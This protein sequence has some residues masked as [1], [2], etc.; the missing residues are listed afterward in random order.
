MAPPG[1]TYGIHGFEGWSFTDRKEHWIPEASSG[2]I[3][4]SSRTERIQAL[5]LTEEE[6]KT[7][8]QGREMTGLG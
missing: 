2:F 5:N 4:P 6:S 8:L 7:A 3:P 1:T